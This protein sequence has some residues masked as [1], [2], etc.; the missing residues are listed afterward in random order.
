[1]LQV[2]TTN[3]TLFQ[4]GMSLVSCK[5]SL[6]PTPTWPC[7]CQLTSPT[8]E[9]QGDANICWVITLPPRWWSNPLP[10]CPH[11]WAEECIFLWKGINPPPLSTIAD[12]TICLIT[13]QALCASL[14]NLSSYGLCIHKFHLFCDI[15]TVPEVDHLLASFELLHSFAIWAVTDP[16]TFGPGLPAN[17]WFKPVS[18]SIVKISSCNLCLAF[19]SR[20]V[21]TRD[22]HR[23]R[24]THGF[25]IT[26]LAGTGMVVDF[27][28]L[29][30]TVYLYCGITG[31]HRYVAI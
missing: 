27:S 14:Q 28:T 31:I 1:M 12:P 2:M 10:L 13:S 30:H 17:I 5:A 19:G 3:P 29:Q 26:G 8:N 18:V 6:L 9:S 7:H 23:Y 20:M 4:E 11:C 24:K 25:E 22:C 15:F 21:T 16:S